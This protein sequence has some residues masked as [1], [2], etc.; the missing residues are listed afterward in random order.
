VITVPGVTM[1]RRVLA[2]RWFRRAG[3]RD[4]GGVHVRRLS[5]AILVATGLLLHGCGQDVT[6]PHPSL[7]DQ[8]ALHVV[9]SVLPSMVSTL[10]VEV[11][12]PDLAASLIF[13]IVASGS[14][15][16]GTITVP[17]GASRT[18]TISAYDA[19]G[20]ETHRGATTINVQAGDNALVSVAL[21]PRQ[22]QQPID[23]RIEGLV[24]TVT[25][26]TAAM[27]VEQ[28]ASLQAA[29]TTTSGTPIPVPASEIR[30]A[31]LNSSIASVDLQGSVL[32]L[33]AGTATIV[34]VYAGVGGAA[35][36]T[37][38]PA[39]LLMAAGDVAKCQPTLPA[40]A[41]G[42]WTAKLFDAE[43]TATIAMIGDGTYEE[44]TLV[45]YTTCYDLSWGR[46][47][48]R[49]KPVPGNHEYRTAGAA[50][51][52]D[53]FGAAAGDRTKG[54][55]SYDLGA[56]HIVALNSNPPDV[57]FSATSPQITW[58][59][60]DLAASTA[61]CTLLYFHHPLFTSGAEH[62]SEGARSQPAWVAAHAA[63]VDV[64]L[65]AHDHNYERFAR[66]NPQGALDPVNGIRE[67]VVGTGGYDL[68]G[69]HTTIHPN[70]EVRIPDVADAALTS[71]QRKALKSGVLKLELREKSYRWWFIQAD[72]T[73]QGTVLDS[74]SAEC[75]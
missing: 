12:A 49:T 54:Y 74:G 65:G 40:P 20:I 68:M 55:Y 24:V 64:I 23:V 33:N 67:F 57:S 3:R 58:L 11:T 38:Q 41:S 14:R 75:H 25:P 34:A 53:Y 26:G 56:W 44:G 42:E 29:V 18:L 52:F 71:D 28:T 72:G 21:M 43:P 35:T 27:R 69:M 73:A 61:K 47:K 30:W 7:R 16:S 5:T 62:H 6:P 66:Q 2:G 15:A 13:N 19:S 10:V 36:I 17:S 31:T 50:G 39:P 60:A 32:G 45:Q 22:G 48:A 63:K 59:K 70:S 51:Y 9:A 46:H 8:A 4:W 37:V 1:V